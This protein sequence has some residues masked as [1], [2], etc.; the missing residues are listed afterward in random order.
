METGLRLIYIAARR[1]TL[2]GIPSYNNQQM[3]F[4]D[5]ELLDPLV[6]CF[7]RCYWCKNL[8][9]IKE[10]EHGTLALESRECPKCGVE[11][12]EQRIYDT[13][14]ENLFHTSA[15]TSANKFISFDLAVIPFMA[16]SVLIAYMEFP[17]WIRIVNL[18]FYH[19]QI[20]LYLRWFYRYWYFVRFTDTEYLDAVERMK[21][22]LILWTVA[23]LVN[24]VFI[25]LQV[26]YY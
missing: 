18:L 6:H 20:L 23:N 19:M 10:N 11:I 24:W 4:S 16:V 15:I 22:V 12:S 17:V 3:K 14:L 7:A 2:T 8:V 1:S 21:R 13:L 5:P 9:A 26:L 25:I